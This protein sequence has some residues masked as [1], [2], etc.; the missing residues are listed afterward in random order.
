MDQR[1]EIIN[2]SR[3]DLSGKTGVATDFDLVRDADGEFD[4]K[5][6]RYTVVLDGGG[7][8]K[9]RVTQLREERA[10]TRAKGKGKKGRGRK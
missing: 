1:V 8:F 6:A 9:V 3:R 4:W 10:R 2:T 5:S 7:V